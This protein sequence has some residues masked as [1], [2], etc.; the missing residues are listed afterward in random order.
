MGQHLEFTFLSDDKIEQDKLRE[1]LAKIGVTGKKWDGYL[2]GGGY[3]WANWSNSVQPVDI[4]ASNYDGS[5]EKHFVRLG[6]D[7][8]VLRRLA[9]RDHRKVLVDEF[10]KLGSQLWRAF[11]FYEGALSPEEQGWFLY[12]LRQS[13]AEEI[14]RGLPL[15]NF[16]TF[17]SHDAA[18]I[19]QAY[20]WVPQAHPH[21]TI[22]P[23]ERESLLI[24]WD[25]SSEG[26]ARFLSAEFSIQ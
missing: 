13:S 5:W 17:L 15:S 23:L 2:N 16:A 7:S 21:S 1:V 10:L 4:F 25:S 26:L 12:S 3:G 20:Q 19:V 9:S 8:S 11:P 22:T 18:E 24:V 6:F 14:R